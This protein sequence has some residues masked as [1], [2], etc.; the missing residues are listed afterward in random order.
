M[1]IANSTQKKDNQKN[2][3][4]GAVIRKI[5]LVSLGRER[6]KNLETAA[7]LRARQREL[8]NVISNVGYDHVIEKGVNNKEIKFTETIKLLKK[9]L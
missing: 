4:H 8:G 6:N 2:Y 5:N 9:L 1:V 7:L 3:K